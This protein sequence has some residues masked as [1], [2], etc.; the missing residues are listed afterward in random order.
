MTLPRLLLAVLLSFNV[1]LLA[2]SLSPEYPAAATVLKPAALTQLLP[3]VAS[4]GVDFLAAWYDERA[5]ATGSRIRF[6]TISGDGVLGS[7]TGTPVADAP[8]GAYPTALFW[9]GR[10]YVLISTNAFSF[11]VRIS[12][13]GEAVSPR[14][15]L[16]I[17]ASGLH[18]I[19]SN[20]GT[21]LVLSNEGGSPSDRVLIGYLFDADFNFITHFQV[22][23]AVPGTFA[24][25]PTADGTGYMLVFNTLSG[26]SAMPVS[27][28]GVMGGILP[29]S[30][31]GN[32]LFLT[33]NRNGYL[34][35][36][37]GNGEEGTAV[38]VARLDLAGRVVEPFRRLDNG[39][40]SSALGIDDHWLVP[41]SSTAPTSNIDV[42]RVSA[43]SV[44]PGTPLTHAAGS[45][46][47]P[48]MASNGDRVIFVWTDSRRSQTGYSTRDV[49]FAFTNRS[50][51]PLEGSDDERGRALTLSPSVQQAPAIVWGA[52]GY[53]V[54]WVEPDGSFPSAIYASRLDESGQLLDGS[55]IRLDVTDHPKLGPAVSFDGENYVVVW[56]EGSLQDPSLVFVRV[57]TDG[58]VL[59]A[60][61]VEIARPFAANHR[62]SVASVSGGSLVVF[63][64]IAAGDEQ[65]AI[66]RISRSGQVLDPGG[67]TISAGPRAVTLDVATSGSDYAVVWADHFQNIFTS[68]VDLEGNASTPQAVA[69]GLEPVVAWNGQ[70]YLVA[71][72]SA[73]GIRG[74]FVGEVVDRL[75][76]PNSYG[77]FGE[78]SRDLAFDG[79][80][81]VLTWEVPAAYERGIPVGTPPPV[82]I[83][84]IHARF[85]AA[86]G[87]PLGD[88]EGLRISTTEGLPD[89]TPAVAAH[90]GTAAITYSRVATEPAHTGVRRAFV[91]FL[92]K[93][94][95]RA[96]PVH[97]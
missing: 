89:S 15:D 65:V 88:E 91:R 11:A 7:Q 78:R 77:S 13:D 72:S 1:P 96:R 93:A 33:S 73:D 47:G 55:G 18:R 14:V 61:P 5:T 8:D 50:G 63:K 29:L 39:V 36:S 31:S 95:T 40:S 16:N 17:P 25:A 44:E 38:D 2:V 27:S 43:Q 45:Q 86:D 35:I 24:A 41:V 48:S 53:L 22:P 84:D 68:I 30:A 92:R 37:H 21:F 58:Q 81:F 54:S 9:T 56:R 10:D 23:T 59:D 46:A 12:R 57:S 79:T 87:T 42:H 3:L 80:H 32:L 62:Y 94:I 20:G 4:D 28:Q 85:I 49:M 34:L 19:S 64:A 66:A 83:P 90:D 75:L 69:N 6:T 97:R 74:R 76:A 60:S 51:E 52:D 70:R 67:R 71:Y 82:P 26:I